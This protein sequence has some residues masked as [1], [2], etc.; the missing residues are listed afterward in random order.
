MRAGG[1]LRGPRTISLALVAGLIAFETILALSAGVVGIP[2]VILVAFERASSDTENTRDP[3]PPAGGESDVAK[4]S[5]VPGTLSQP[6][7]EDAAKPQSPAPQ[8]GQPLLSGL[9]DIPFTPLDPSKPDKPDQRQHVAAN[10]A[11]RE[12][13]PWADTEPVPYPAEGAAP[14]P[15]DST[16]A[17]P[18]ASGPRP[19]VPPLELPTSREVEAWVKEAATEIKGEERARPLYHFEFWLDPPDELRRRVVAV[20]YEFN[21][22][23]VMPQTQVSSEQK[24]GFRVSAGG[25]A[26]ADKVTITLKFDD[27]RTEQVAV[28]GCKLLS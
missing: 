10:T 26:C 9:A 14:V 23:A 15:A 21:T 20:V 28:D 7:V 12:V 16:A 22:P 17:L 8:S 24:T 13:L 5:A 11:G 1:K 27:G 25:L 18:P 3:A 4:L 6:P 2:G 19:R